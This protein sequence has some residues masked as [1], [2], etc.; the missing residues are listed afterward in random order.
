[1]AY[2]KNYPS[3]GW[4]DEPAETTPITAA[5]LNHLE[6]GIA[7]AAE[8]ADGALPMPSGTAGAGK[9]PV[10]TDGSGATAWG[11][12]TV[13]VSSVNTHT[14]AVVLA[15]ADVGA[16]AAAAAGAA[17]GVATLDF[18]SRVPV[19]QVP[20]LPFYAPTGKTGATAPG[21][22]A[23]CTTSGNPVSGT[24]AVG[25]WVIDVKNNL[26]RVCV[27]AG[28]PGTWRRAGQKANE[29]YVDDFGCVADG[30]LVNDAIMVSGSNVLNF[31]SATPLTSTL[32]DGGKAIMVSTATGTFTHGHGTITTVNSTSQAVLS[33][34]ATANTGGTPGA[35]A[36]WGTDNTVPYQAC[37]DTARAYMVA[38]PRQ[39]AV[40]YH[41]GGIY[42]IDGPFIKNAVGNPGNYQL[43]L[44]VQDP[45]L[46]QLNPVLLGV[47]GTPGQEHWL[48]DWPEAS[49]TVLASTRIDGT[50]DSTYGTACLLGGPFAGYGG[51]P[52]LFSNIRPTIRNI[53][54]LVP[55]GSV[56]CS[57]I[58]LYGYISHDVSDMRDSA[59]AVPVVGGPAPSMSNPNHI[60][61]QNGYGFRASVTGNQTACLVGNFASAGRTYGI[62]VSEWSKV[63]RA[64]VMYSIG[65]VGCGYGG[66]SMVH[67][68]HMVDVQAENCANAVIVIDGAS[69]V[70]L[71]ID[72]LQTEA[73]LSTVI[74]DPANRLNGYIVVENQGGDGEFRNYGGTGSANLTLVNGMTQPGFVTLSGASAKPASGATWVNYFYQVAEI[75]L[76]VAGGTITG[77]TTDGTSEIVPSGATW[78]RFGLRPGGAF[79]PAFTGALT[80]SCKLL[81]RR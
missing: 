38:H 67:K 36:F 44:G 51:E 24:F 62:G 45:T 76:S 52:G 25:D 53:N 60:T 40:I 70:R 54:T 48:Q 22:W 33:F 8:T 71:S 47:E 19:A 80:M 26:I 30:V 7:D 32:V 50:D 14:G 5:T 42:V 56:F 17:S 4:A 49:G 1:M 73:L 12:I 27:A 68:A 9:V 2:T 39:R 46:P 69:G 59:A 34:T 55:Y 58:D 35:I 78:Y 74:Y 3:G 64:H 10:G 81:D 20:Q 16:I 77:V 79:V 11:T 63:A 23:G 18:N 41:S 57:G 72:C 28:T 31:A 29:F 15:A 66:T 43:T 21:E 65:A 37:L 75:T 13:P 6:Q 61:A